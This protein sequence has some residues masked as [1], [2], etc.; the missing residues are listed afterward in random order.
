MWWLAW[1]P[2]GISVAVLLGWFYPYQY[3]RTKLNTLSYQTRHLA[4]YLLSREDAEI[5]HAYFV[6]H[7]AHNCHNYKI[8][9][10]RKRGPCR[11]QQLLGA[12]AGGDGTFE[13]VTAEV[14]VVMGPSHN[15]HGIPTTPKMLGLTK[16]TVINGGADSSRVFEENENIVV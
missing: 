4:T 8:I 1:A 10:P 5:H 3:I 11:F 16:L 12:R 15:F 9:A 2:V 7:Y 14:K 13:D 6:I